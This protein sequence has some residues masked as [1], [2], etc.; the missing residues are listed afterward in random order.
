[1]THTHQIYYLPLCILFRSLEH[2]IRNTRFRNKEDR[3]T[4]SFL[5]GSKNQ[6]GIKDTSVYSPL[7]HIIFCGCVTVIAEV[8]LEKNV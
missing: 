2:S 4:F 1:M 8:E 7:Y 6:T 3:E 5:K